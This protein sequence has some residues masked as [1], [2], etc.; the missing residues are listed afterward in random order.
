M[1]DKAVLNEVSQEFPMNMLLPIMLLSLA[2]AHDA[3]AQ[4]PE[5]KG[6]AI[7]QEMDRRDRGWKDQ[8][9][10]L[11]MILRNRRGQESRRELRIRTLEVE[12]DGDKSLTLFDSP[13]DVKGT[14]FLSF[15]HATEPDDQWLYLPALKR[16]KRIS[17][18]NKSGSFMGSEFAYEDLS[19]QEVEKYSYKWLRDETLDGKPVSVVEYYPAYE[20]SGY[21]RQVVWIDSEIRQVVRTEYYDRKDTPLKTLAIEGYRLYLDR[22]WRA[23]TMHMVN[24]QNGKSTEIRWSDY[25]FDTG[26]TDRDFDRNALKRAR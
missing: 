1:L 9:A 26:L 7:V 16:V 19:S 20:N 14:A 21:T 13:R 4:S 22:Y 18:R 12:G 3:H 11:V 2:L 5:E 25:E 10:N 24:H 17:S 6:L 8:R 15:T 23:D